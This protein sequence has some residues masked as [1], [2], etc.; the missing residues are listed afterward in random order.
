MTRAAQQPPFVRRL[1]PVAGV[2]GIKALRLA[3]KTLLRRYR[4]RCL[5]VVQENGNRRSDASEQSKSAP[6]GCRSRRR[7]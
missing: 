3:L 4:L 1:G 7:E 6:A 2:D 5:S